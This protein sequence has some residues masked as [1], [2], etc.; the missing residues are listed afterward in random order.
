MG[1]GIF[2][3][4]SMVTTYLVVDDSVLVRHAQ[5]LNPCSNIVDFGSDRKLFGNLRCH[6]C[7]RPQL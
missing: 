3:L 4:T 6:L 2:S 1:Q 5:T 7:Q